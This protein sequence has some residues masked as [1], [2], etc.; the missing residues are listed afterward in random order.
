[1][2]AC[3]G[4]AVILTRDRCETT[5]LPDLVVNAPAMPIATFERYCDNV[6]AILTYPRVFLLSVLAVLCLHLLANRRTDPD[7]F[8]RVAMGRL[9]ERDVAIPMV[10][11]FAFTEKHPSWVDHEWLAGVFFYWT[12]ARGGDWLLMVVKLAFAC[13]STSVLW[14]AM[15]RVVERCKAC[16]V[17]FVYCAF[18]SS[19]VW[20]STVRAQVFTYLIL[21]LVLYAMVDW[22]QTRRS[23]WFWALAC[24]M[25]IWINAHGG[26]VAGLGLWGLF[27]TSLVVTGNW[28]AATPIAG[29]FLLG[30]GAM[31]ANPYGL[32]SYCSYI[33][34][35]TTMSRPDIVEW[36]ALS[37]ADAHGLFWLISVALLVFGATQ[38]STRNIPGLVVIAAAAWAAFRSYRLLPIFYMTSAVFGGP[39]VVAVVSCLSGKGMDRLGLVLVRSAALVWSLLCVWAVG[40]ITWFTVCAHSFALDYTGYPTSACDWLLAN[41]AAGRVLIDFNHGSFALWRLHPYFLVSMDGRYEEVYLDNTVA[42]VAQALDS[43][44]SNHLPALEAIDPD[45][46]LV[47]AKRKWQAKGFEKVYADSAF[48]IYET[49]SRPFA[50]PPSS[51]EPVAL[52]TPRF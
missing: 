31:A 49:I 13:A 50:A 30:L 21:A 39:Y 2:P 40:T 41:R 24:V 32:A 33:L 37:L 36:S 12:A 4:S 25:P 22:Q 16:D 52:W 20:I 35:A 6:V 46:V 18:Q 1:M 34:R 26:F 11:P 5:Q 47:P 42:L 9:V 43:T 48:L 7:L 3:R 19:L 29:S 51:R 38:S 15:R 23:R 14:A 17:W 27:V 10:D 8:A 28:R 45:F 44:N